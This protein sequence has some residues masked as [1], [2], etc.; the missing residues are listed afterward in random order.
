[1][2]VIE[3]LAIFLIIFIRYK[4][5]RCNITYSYFDWILL[6]VGKVEWYLYITGDCISIELK[7]SNRILK[8]KFLQVIIITF[9]V[10]R[11]EWFLQNVRLVCTAAGQQDEDKPVRGEACRTDGHSN[12]GNISQNWELQVNRP[13]RHED[14]KTT[15]KA[16]L[17]QI[18]D[19]HRGCHHKPKSTTETRPLIGPQCY[20]LTHFDAP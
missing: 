20:Q 8:S 5:A 16:C 18:R 12:N 4:S 2:F 9:L 14:K 15:L 6:G 7:M 13:N 3:L 11:Q 19:R 17:G 1:M 10:G